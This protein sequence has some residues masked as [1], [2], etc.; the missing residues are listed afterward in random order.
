MLA[1][2]FLGLSDVTPGSNE[3]IEK[4]SASVEVYFPGSLVS[5][6]GHATV[7]GSSVYVLPPGVLATGSVTFTYL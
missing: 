4:A 6:I 7:T 2:G 5:F 3:T 1:R